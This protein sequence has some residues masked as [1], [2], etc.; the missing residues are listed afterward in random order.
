MIDLPS[1]S[2]V[3]FHSHVISPEGKYQRYITNGFLSHETGRFYG[4]KLVK[5]TSNGI[6]LVN[7]LKIP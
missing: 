3:I 1:N 2:M 7:H 5:T 6:S 4:V